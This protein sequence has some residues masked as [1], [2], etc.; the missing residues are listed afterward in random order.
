MIVK[1][2]V[3]NRIYILLLLAIIIQSTRTQAQ[4]PEFSQFYANPVYTNPA[5][6]GSSN[7][8][9]G[10]MNIRSQWPN[11]AG[12][13]RTISLSYDEHYDAINGGIGI[14]LTGD[15]AGAG[16]L[17]TLSATGVYSYQIVINRHL[18][19]RAAVQAS[20]TQKSLDFGKL[21]FSDQIVLQQG[22]IYATQ[23]QP[24]HS[25]VYFAN[26]AAGVVAYTSRFY[27]GFAVHN[28]TEPNQAFYN[29]KPDESIIPMRY[30][31]HAGLVIPLVESRD[32]KRASNLWPNI[33]YM[34]QRQYNQLN[35][36]MYYNRGP[37]VLG[38]FYRQ[39]SANADA[40]IGL[41]GIRSNKLRIGYSYDQTLSAARTGAPNS[42]E[43]SLAVEL[44]KRVPRK[45]IR[46]IKCPEF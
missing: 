38:A 10:V 3:Q 14:M 2:S 34:Q 12:S 7:V 43:V 26:F 8:G 33:L 37:F 39:N 40:I 4:D 16:L 20:I 46:A 22:F 41:L 27:G 35:L 36:G 25:N 1:H 18:T 6:A 15:Q 23:E 24:P 28:L 19:M 45:T 30:T 32:A 13:F 11:I 29:L 5:F 21:Q 44:R 17:N 31:A 9:R 42:H